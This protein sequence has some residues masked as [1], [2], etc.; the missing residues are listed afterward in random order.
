MQPILSPQKE[1]LGESKVLIT[2]M[3]YQKTSS[4]NLT[5]LPSNVFTIL[6]HLSP[7]QMVLAHLYKPGATILVGPQGSALLGFFYI[8]R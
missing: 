8:L 5:E 2:F 7:R 6:L 1:S 3:F 4:I